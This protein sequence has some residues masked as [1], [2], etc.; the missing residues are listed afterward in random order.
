MPRRPV[1]LTP[2]ALA[3]QS[4]LTYAQVLTDIRSGDL[5]ALTVRRGTRTRY[6]VTLEASEAWL[7]R[8]GVRHLEAECLEIC[9]I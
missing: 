8:I 9:R 7:I 5:I 2:M 6:L 1:Y 3:Q 4:G